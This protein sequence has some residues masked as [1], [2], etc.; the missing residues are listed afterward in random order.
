MT[1]CSFVLNMQPSVENVI[2][3]QEFEMQMKMIHRIYD[4]LENLSSSVEMHSR[5][6]WDDWD[7]MKYLRIS[8]STLKRCRKAKKNPIKFFRVGAGYR[9]HRADILAHKNEHLK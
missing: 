3:R 5:D 4:I 2:T 8:E 1:S 9:Y 7:V 6:V